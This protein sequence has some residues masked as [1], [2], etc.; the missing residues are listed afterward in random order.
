MRFWRISITLALGLAVLWSGGLSAAV[1]VPTVAAQDGGSCEELTAQ[2]IQAA[3]ETCADVARGEACLATASALESDRERI[4]TE[5]AR[6]PL[7]DLRALYTSADATANAWGVAVAALTAGL[8]DEAG[9]VTAVFFGETETA[10]P[11]QQAD[12]RP[13]LT[14][15]NRGGSPINV[16]NGAAVTYAV[17]GQMA[18]GEEALADGRNEQAD[19]VRVQ[20][21]G[22][23]GWVFVPLIGWDGDWDALNALEVLLPNDVTPPVQAAEPFQA[24]TFTSGAAICPQAPSGLLLQYAGEQT[25]SVIVD[26]VTLDF[27]DATLLITAQPNDALEV[28]ALSG[29]ATITARGI[30]QEVERGQGVRV[31]LGGEDGLTPLSD[32]QVLRTYAF[33]SVAYAPL[34]LLPQPTACT[35]GLPSE[36]AQVSLRVGPGEERGVLAAMSAQASYPVIGWA[37]APDGSP[38]WQLD[39]GETPT[40]APQSA[41]R[42]LGA[43]E[44]VAE[45]EP[46]PLIMAAP[47]ISSVEGEQGAPMSGVDFAPTANSVWQ[48]RPGTDHMSG[49]CSGAPAINFCDHL[50]AITP[51]EGGIMWRGMEPTPYFL[52]RVQ[53]NVY[54]YSGPNVQ[55]TGTVTLTL[56]F[57]S[58]TTLSMTMALVLNSEPNCQHTYYYSGTR[59]W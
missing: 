24:L 23:I 47:P 27:A 4:N 55:G 26:Q 56:T 25:A 15:Y 46:P 8:P 57:T 42:A 53:P 18:G 2:A 49:S 58:E 31:T 54:A 17:V 36:D 52:A 6:I 3:Q 30:P 35:V 41:V 45:V 1:R 37:A 14:V 20:F 34:E 44:A 40:W 50:A 5:G 32:P 43:C 51:A 59:N 21:S 10:A 28:K 39:T 19:W 48:M 11:A 29:A 9:A 22:G 13:T 16:R 12:Q 7:A 38:W 33:P